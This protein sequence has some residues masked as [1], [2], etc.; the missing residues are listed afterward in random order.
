MYGMCIKKHLSTLMKYVLKNVFHIL[1][2]QFDTA[3]FDFNNHFTVSCRVRSQYE[4]VKKIHA[5]F[6]PQL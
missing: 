5:L 2:T 6:Q 3:L 1:G 4:K